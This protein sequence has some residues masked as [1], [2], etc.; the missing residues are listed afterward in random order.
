MPIIRPRKDNDDD[1]FDEDDSA[2]SFNGEHRS[3]GSATY[4]SSRAYI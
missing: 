2:S 3:A 4:S 1:D